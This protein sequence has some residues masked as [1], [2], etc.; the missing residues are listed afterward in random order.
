[1]SGGHA[2]ADVM[3]E[4]GLAV[5]ARLPVLL[6]SLIGAGDRVLDPT[7][8]AGLHPLVIPLV[9][10]TDGSVIGMLRWPTPDPGMQMPLVRQRPD[11]PETL[12]LVAI[13]TDAW[14]HRDLAMR[15]SAGERLPDALLDAVNAPGE[16]YYAGQLEGSGLPLK[17]YLLLKVGET[18]AFFEELVEA[19]L[20]KGD[21]TAAAV[22]ADRACRQDHGWARPWVF[23]AH[24]LERL[25]QH[26]EARDTARLALAEPVWT[27][28]H[29]FE[30][31]ARLAGWQKITSIAYQKL[32]D[33][34]DKPPADR[35]AHRMDQTA[36]DGGDWD[37][38]R[39]ELAG[40]YREAGLEGVA[41]L[42]RG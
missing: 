41:R 39:D 34:A 5:P 40:L 4:A 23:R 20:D 1:M 42:V 3:V 37:A 14:L 28:G 35:A 38:I 7:D 6:T 27:F 36:I 10:E 16:L 22:T 19:H 18:H 8:R 11:H 24:L 21:E 15:E 33:N 29:P 31:L 9:G 2:H 17:A 32:A 12:D 13:S 30:P 26:D 25:G